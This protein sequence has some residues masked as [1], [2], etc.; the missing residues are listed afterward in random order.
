MIA[1]AVSVPDVAILAP[2]AAAGICALIY[3][4]GKVGEWIGSAPTDL[5]EPHPPV[6]EPVSHVN[7]DPVGRTLHVGI[8]VH[9]KACDAGDKLECVCG[10]E[11]SA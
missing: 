6:S 4:A 7:L 5:W 2:A 9:A 1:A 11:V 3:V 8:D 10:L